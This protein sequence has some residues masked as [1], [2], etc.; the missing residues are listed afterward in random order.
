MNNGY[1]LVYDFDGTVADTFQPS[2]NGVGVY[3]AYRLAVNNIF[4]QDGLKIYDQAG[5][6]QNRA[7]EEIV[8]LV[9]A[10]NDQMIKQ[11]EVCFDQKNKTLRRLVPDG[12]GAPLK[13]INGDKNCLQK[14]ITEM[15]VLIKL[16]YL[17]DEIGTSFSDGAV[18]PRPC[19]GFW[20]F[21]RAIEDLRMENLDI[22]NAIISSGHD[23]FIKKTFAVWG[24]DP[25][26]IML[27]DDDMR[28]RNYPAEFQKRVK[29]S[30]YLFDIIQ[31]SWI[32]DGILFSEYARHIE[33]IYDT[34]RRMM[35]FGDDLN[36]DGGLAMSAGVPFG[37][38]DPKQVHN[39]K[40]SNSFFAFGDWRDVARFFRR[41]DV[42]KLLSEGQ[43]IIRVV[44]CF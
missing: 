17:M 41:N 20:D 22:Q 5:G 2:P 14:T 27:T 23:E 4:G 30:S 15:L 38:F 12:K 33:L 26:R 37:L 9:L 29:P 44:S 36:K 28:G 43:P 10:G 25:P 6:L 21:I 39:Y 11:A 31:S 24:F 3:E 40:H 42:K 7:P 32:S 1:L 8:S 13:W 18:W 34:R 35:Y 19:V 16:S